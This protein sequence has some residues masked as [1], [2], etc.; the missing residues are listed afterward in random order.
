MHKFY[1]AT[2]AN[3]KKYWLKS[4]GVYGE[5]TFCEWTSKLQQAMKF[6]KQEDADRYFKKYF[7]KRFPEVELDR[8]FD[9]YGA[10]DYGI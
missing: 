9:V 1:I 10:Y 7:I 5:L 4:H 8:Q 6:E 2:K 3:R